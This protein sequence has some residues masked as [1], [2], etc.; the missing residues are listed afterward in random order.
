MGKDVNERTRRASPSHNLWQC[1]TA[2]AQMIRPSAELGD[3]ISSP[4]LFLDERVPTDKSH[5]LLFDSSIF[6]N[7]K[8]LGLRCFLDAIVAYFRSTVSTRVPRY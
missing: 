3:R 7:L 1:H 8:R 6:T 2:A 4:G 5:L